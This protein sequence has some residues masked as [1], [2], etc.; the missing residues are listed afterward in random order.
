MLI[1]HVHNSIGHHAVGLR[2]VILHGKDRA[3]LLTHSPDT[4]MDLHPTHDPGVGAQAAAHQARLGLSVPAPA[5]LVAQHLFDARPRESGEE[6]EEPQHAA[7]DV[8]FAVEAEGNVTGREL[9]AHVAGGKAA[10]LP[11]DD[12]GSPNGSKTRTAPRL[13]RQT[14]RRPGRRP[15]RPTPPE[16]WIIAPTWMP[17]SSRSIGTRQSE[18]FPARRCAIR[19]RAHWHAQGYDRRWRPGRPAPQ[20]RALHPAFAVT[21][22]EVDGCQL[23]PSDATDRFPAACSSVIR[24]DRT[25]SF[26][27]RPH[28]PGGRAR[29]RSHWTVPMI[30]LA[31]VLPVPS[32][33]KALAG[34][35]RR[36]FCRARCLGRKA[37]RPQV[38]S[39]QPRSVPSPSRAGCAAFPLIP[40]AHFRPRSA[41]GPMVRA[42]MCPRRPLPQD[43]GGQTPTLPVDKV[44][45]VGWAPAH[46]SGPS[47]NAPRHPTA[48]RSPAG[49]RPSHSLRHPTTATPP[50][51]R[52][53]R[54]CRGGPSGR[55][56]PD[57]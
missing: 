18:L 28:P 48:R 51:R 2:A 1:G 39:R 3:D 24:S 37:G 10:L 38:D 45:P 46:H 44:R 42:R 47:S 17:A 8:G 22:G 13:G 40:P 35:S 52:L 9:V 11:G 34:P 15:C 54:R 25:S 49:S 41:P 31:S 21:N 53:R 50:L 32:W 43:W 36:D 27:R 6:V 57:A 33:M 20:G 5:A 23:S 19:R 14:G 4:R 30:T 7:L 16:S 55:S 56:R 26:V 12:D 29:G